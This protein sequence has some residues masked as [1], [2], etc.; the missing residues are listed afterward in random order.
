MPR[1]WREIELV[2][3]ESQRLRAALVALA[4]ESFADHVEL[5][6]GAGRG[7][8]CAGARGDRDRRAADRL[9]LKPDAAEMTLR[10]FC[11]R[12]WPC[13]GGRGRYIENS[14]SAELALGEDANE[15]NLAKLREIQAELSGIEG[16]EAAV[17]GFGY[18]PDARAS[19]CEAE[20]PRADLALRVCFRLVRA[21]LRPVAA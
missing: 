9:G 8:D 4:S 7:R 17:E 1:I 11:G 18:P 21:D 2:G 19:L 20:A 14:K 3:R 5:A 12:R 10:R 13:I 6:H 16:R 15:H